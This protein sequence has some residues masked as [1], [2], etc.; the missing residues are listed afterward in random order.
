MG[1]AGTG[2][3]ASD[4]LSVPWEPDPPELVWT[5]AQ[6][7]LRELRRIPP[8]SRAAH[9]LAQHAARATIASIYFS[10][11]IDDKGPS[12]AESEKLIR[13]EQLL[14]GP[15]APPPDGA[16]A[17]APVADAPAAATQHADASAA[18]AV[19]RREV[20]QHAAAWR[21]LHRHAVT[22]RRPLT[23]AVVLETHRILVSGLPPTIEDD[24]QPAAAGA[25]RRGA[26]YAGYHRFPPAT[27]VQS[28]V[29]DLL[30]EYNT[31]A[32]AAA[33]A[34]STGAIVDA[35]HGGDPFA[36]AAWLSYNFDAVHPFVDGNGRMSR[37]LLNA[38]LLAAGVP[39]CS[40]LG[41]ASGHRQAKKQYLQCVRH[42]DERGGGGGGSGD[43]GGGAPRLLATVVLCGF[44]DAA[45]SYFEALRMSYPGEYPE[46]LKRLYG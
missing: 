42:A 46:T 36:L 22:D 18:A 39:F 16:A 1:S 35:E 32:A 37:L 38:A 13:E 27:V 33:A 12:L 10:N 21:H 2:F 3:C 6:L 14:P 25:Y 28:A 5:Q 34:A 24:G 43:D 20:L 15:E 26:V 11:H 23:E 7:L 29:R 19:V 31:R 8:A 45:A 30:H 41:F 9:L 17:D 4:Y 40:A 44:R